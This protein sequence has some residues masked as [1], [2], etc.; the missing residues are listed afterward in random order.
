MTD[1]SRVL[2]VPVLQTISGYPGRSSKLQKPPNS[3]VVDESILI[4]NFSK[5]SYN[6]VSLKIQTLLEGNTLISFEEQRGERDLLKP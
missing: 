5:E 1:C 6:E 4:H 2:S 3:K